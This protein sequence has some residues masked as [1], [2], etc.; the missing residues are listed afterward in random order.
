MAGNIA[1]AAVLYDRAD[2]TFFC[3]HREGVHQFYWRFTSE[4]IQEALDAVMDAAADS[5]LSYA[6]AAII[7]QGMRLAVI[8]L[9]GTEGTHGQAFH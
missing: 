3:S 2:Q 4:Q 6:S 1:Q 9:E 5:L 7:T 8:E